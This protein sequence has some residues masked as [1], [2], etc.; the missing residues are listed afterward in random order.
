MGYD[1]LIHGGTIV[2]SNGR[3]PGQVAVQGGKIAAI[4]SPKVEAEAKKTYDA[5]GLYILP[6]LIDAHVHFRDPGFTEKEDFET[7]TRSAAA[8]GI[9]MVIDMPNVSPP[10][11]TAANLEEKL[12]AISPKAAVDFGLFSVL[13]EENEGEMAA[14]AKGGVAGFK[15]YIGT[16][17]GNI[18]APQDGRMLNQLSQA[19]KLGYRTG[20]HAENNEINDF[21]TAALQKAGEEDPSCLVRARPSVSEASAVAKAISFAEAAGAKI[22]IYHVSAKESVSLIRE[23]KARGVA[24]TAETCPQYLLYSV[25]DYPA[26]GAKGKCFPPIRYKEDQ[27]A[28]WEGLADGTLDMV[29]TDHAPHT[30]AEKAGGLWQCMA[31]VIGVETSVPL[32]LTEVG[33]GRLTL[34]EYVRLASENP[35]KLWGFYPQKGSLLPGTDADLTI[36]DL[37]REGTIRNSDLHGKSKEG[38]FDGVKTKGKAVSALVRGRFVLKDEVLLTEPGYGRLVRP[39]VPSY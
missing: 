17:V 33:R 19:A 12:R 9:T 15:I 27:A 4:L 6:G 3:F 5:T 2:T 30:A 25:E 21:C 14:L 24:V 16:S 13:V 23:A 7:G 1:L 11:T 32:F 28:L 18:A 8:G 34:E 37:E 39:I 26:L 20:F 10:T 31:G 22:H 29:A 38:V 35:A 36:V